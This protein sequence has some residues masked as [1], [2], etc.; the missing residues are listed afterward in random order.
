MNLFLG[1]LIKIKRK[2]KERIGNLN[3]SKIILVRVNF[4]I[5]NLRGGYQ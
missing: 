2:E 1:A 3:T 4:C 5:N